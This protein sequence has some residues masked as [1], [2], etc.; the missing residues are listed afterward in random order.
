MTSSLSSGAEEM[1]LDILLAYDQR[2]YTV[3]N[4]N[5]GTYDISVTAYNTNGKGN[6]GEVITI[7]LATPGI[8]R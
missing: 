1:V 4:L 6:E 5:N 3:Y 8:K 2:N 7:T